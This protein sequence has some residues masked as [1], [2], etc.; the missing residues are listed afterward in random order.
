[1]PNPPQDPGNTRFIMEQ[2]EQGKRLEEL[3]S[4]RELPTLAA[5]LNG[6]MGRR[7]LSTE[8]LFE[9]ACLNRATGFKV[10][11]GKMMPSQNVLLRLALVLRLTIEETQWMLK[12]GRHATLS[13]SRARDV[14]LM[15]AIHDQ[16]SIDEADAL[17]SAHEQLPL[18][19]TS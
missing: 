12:C 18:S 3:Q 14:L 6:L 11:A 5:V 8:A 7:S 1:M 19:K 10:L 13:G 15:K 2:I 17:L 9:Q 16:L 4:P